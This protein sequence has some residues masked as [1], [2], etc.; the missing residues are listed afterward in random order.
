M[1][2][3]EYSDGKGGGAAPQSST[4]T[5]PDREDRNSISGKQGSITEQEF[6]DRIRKSDRWMIAL[7][8]VLAFTGII[9][10]FIF[11]WQLLAMQGQL[12]EMRLDQ[13]PWLR[14]T[15]KI[16]GPLYSKGGMLSMVVE[17]TVSNSGHT[18]AGGVRGGAMITSHGHRIVT[19]GDIQ[20]VCARSASLALDRDSAADLIFPDRADSLRVE[21]IDQRSTGQEGEILPP[22]DQVIL[23]ND[24][25]LVYCVSYL[26]AENGPLRHTGGAFVIGGIKSGLILKDGEMI[27]PS[28]LSLERAPFDLKWR[29]YAD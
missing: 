29:S 25:A 3:E 7:T 19:G 4:K 14:A 18:P 22:T 15:P 27:D 28:E 12:D 5:I 6:V 24:T 9:S 26:N 21:A 11:G 8:G 17:I 13:R 1:E 20:E 10:A 16:V 2:G 23:G